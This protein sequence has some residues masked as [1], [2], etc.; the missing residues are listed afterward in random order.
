MVTKTQE[1][2]DQMSP[3]E[4]NAHFAAEH[5]TVFGEG[6]RKEHGIGAAGHE[7]LNH[8]NSIRKYEGED[9]YWEAIAAAWK[10]DAKRAKVLGLPPPKKVEKAA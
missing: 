4:R 6:N 5:D 8:F 1:E 3:A 7:T 2:L 9:A 10:R